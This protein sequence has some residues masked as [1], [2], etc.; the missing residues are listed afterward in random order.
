MK[1]EKRRGPIFI[2]IVI[3]ILI[4]VG[5][6]YLSVSWFVNVLVAFVIGGL[7]N[8]LDEQGEETLKSYVIVISLTLAAIMLWT[9]VDSFY[10][11]TPEDMT[12]KSRERLLKE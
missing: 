9:V 3:S 11:T 1:V 2:G 12:Q 6:H 5:L 8:M 7:I 10:E 4:G